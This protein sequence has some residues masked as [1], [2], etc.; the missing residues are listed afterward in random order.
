M[1]E[2]FY[3]KEIEAGENELKKMQGQMLADT[4]HF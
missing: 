1:Q 3:E 2:K 4:M